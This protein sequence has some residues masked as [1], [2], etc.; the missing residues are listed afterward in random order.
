MDVNLTQM[1]SIGVLFAGLGLLFWGLGSF[2]K[3]LSKF[4]KID[5][6][7]RAINKK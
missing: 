1:I 6:E 2:F 7:T 4:I 3:G 5:G